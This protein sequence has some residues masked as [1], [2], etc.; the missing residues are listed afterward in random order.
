MGSHSSSS[1]A[2]GL[3]SSSSSN[4]NNNNGGWRKMGGFGRAF[5]L[6]TTT[7]PPRA[8]S[9]GSTSGRHRR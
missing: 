6:S 3:L 5:G 4:N 9:T 2:D 7:R 8:S 1:L